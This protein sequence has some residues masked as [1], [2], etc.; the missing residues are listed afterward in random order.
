MA[1]APLA[2]SQRTGYSREE[3][4]R[5]RAALA[6]RA[7]EGMVVLFGT[8]SPAAGTHIRQ[9]N[10]FFY[11]SGV[12]DLGAILVIN[13]KTGE[14]S[15]FLPRQ[16]PREDMVSGPNL[17][18]DE[19]AKDRLGLTE[20]FDVSYF[21][22]FVAR[23][24]RSFAVTWLRLQP[25]DTVDDSRDEVLIFEGRKNR[26]HYNS[27]ITLDAFRIEKL[28][29]RYPSFE[30]RDVTPFIDSLRSMKSPE[31][32][33]VLRQN[34]KLSAEAIKRAMLTTV[35][36]VFEYEIEAAAM[37]VILKGGARGTAYPPIVGSGPNSCIWHYDAN[38]RKTEWG[39]LVLMDFGADL[40]HL[41]MDITRTWPVTGVFSRDQKEVYRTVLEV[42]KACIEAY[43]PGAT[44]AYVQ[45]HVDDVLKKKGIDSRGL[46]GGFGHFVGMCVHDVGP[47]ITKLEEGMV[48]AIEPALYYPEKDTGIRVEDTVLITKDGCEVLS[49]DVPKEIEEIESLMS[50]NMKKP[51]GEPERVAVQ[52]ILI[53]FKGS[54]PEEKVIRSEGEAKRLAEELFERAKRGEDF[55]ALV[56]KYTDDQYPGVYRMANFGVEP[57]QAKKEYG[58]IRMVKSFGDVSFSLAVGGIGLA[59]YDPRFSKYGWHIIRRLE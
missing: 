1:I 38:S 22:E 28:R 21:D 56:K 48:F 14:S 2:F 29:E 12:E 45:N 33:T 6:E 24:F 40:D 58:R 9:D 16:T 37:Y 41:T 39:D 50:K 47:R 25:A 59:V 8:A 43:R 49:K 26:T 53:A 23:N 36:G 31:E 42:E 30:F 35:P 52:H 7:R 51:A 55:D 3:F 4:V 18:K 11:L 34:G 10:D 27:Q 17:L 32:I 44:L 54:I 15:L 19:K 13:A 20:I 57:D 5:R 46:R